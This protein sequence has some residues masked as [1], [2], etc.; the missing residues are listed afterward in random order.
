MSDNFDFESIKKFLD[1]AESERNDSFSL[2]D[3]M[4]DYSEDESDKKV[5]IDNQTESDE[6]YEELN[7]SFTADT[8]ATESES[9][10]IEQSIEKP[11][12]LS[13]TGPFEAVRNEKKKSQTEK[14]IHLV[15][16]SEECPAPLPAS[17]N[18]TSEKEIFAEIEQKRYF[19]TDTFNSIKEKSVS[20]VKES[21]RSFAVG[22][23]EEDDG[24]EEYYQ[25][26]EPTEE[27]DDFDNQDDREDV[28][29]ELKKINSSASVR[30]FVTFILALLSGVL[31]SVENSWISLPSFDIEK[32][33]NIFVI[34]FFSISVVA[35]L[36][37]LSSLIKGA[38]S[39]LKLRLTVES[40]ILVIFIFNSIVDLSRLFNPSVVNVSFDF[41]YVLILFCNIFSKKI[42]AKT[43]YKNF[44]I[45]SADGDKN[46]INMPDNEQAINDIMLETGCNADIVYASRASFVSDFIS[47]SFKDFES[48]DSILNT[49]LGVV[50]LGLSVLKFVFDKDIVSTFV[51][52]AGAYCVTIPVLFAASFAI[53]LYFNSK[54]ARKYGGVIVGSQS[55]EQLKDVQTV[56]VDDSDVFNAT[57]NG[58]RLYGDSF[59][60][61]A[62]LYLNALY[63]KVGGPLKPLFSDMLSEDIQ[64]VPRI[65]EVYYHD[66][67][68]YSGLIH[69]KVFVAGNK[70]LMDHFGVAVD[71]S[72]YEIIYQQ[73]SR[74]IL[75][76]A[77]DG[78]LMGVFL[79]SYSLS[80]GV[81]KAFK[82][83]EKNQIA[84]CITERDPNINEKTLFDIYEP[85]EKILFNFIS[86]RTARNCFDKFELKSKTPALIAS[87]TGI[88]GLVASLRS[89]KAMRFAFR[90]N[91]VITTIASILAVPLISFLLFFS[92]STAALDTQI[93]AYQLLWSLPVLFVSIFSK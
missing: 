43:V 18:T 87:R 8:I 44:L 26:L 29:K 52:I 22:E 47:N 92:D 89:C 78:K 70:K 57:L 80:H 30:T 51:Y 73:K 20:N 71:D 66:S 14:V 75:F 56:I 79:L 74:H 85:R 53:P 90:S 25:V 55:S 58:I 68:G 82:M 49:V 41:L 45:A 7:S 61:D 93:V 27:I 1:S 40:Y 24:E 88:K 64:S 9:T 36:I 19:N 35:T 38:K 72:E 50:I 6:M 37:N 48:S 23:E 86:F 12:G 16:A 81:A 31:F 28:I 67:M 21:I 77:Y 32:Q 13:V 33:G 2:D 59:I 65:D 91:R 17:Q 69:S 84:V 5:C 15:D 46:I 3:I 11:V 83:C 76:V 63:K 4:R 60:D 54:N 34:I 42:I 62:I 10:F 39:I